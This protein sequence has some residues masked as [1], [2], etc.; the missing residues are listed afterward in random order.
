MIVILTSG[1]GQHAYCLVG[2]RQHVFLSG[3]MDTLSGHMTP[4]VGATGAD[5][6][7]RSMGEVVVETNKRRM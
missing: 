7:L 1:I 3:H 2:R 4:L 6:Y 5:L